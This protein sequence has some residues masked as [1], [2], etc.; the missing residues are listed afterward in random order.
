M[1]Q[2][3]LK[4]YLTYSPDTGLFH[5]ILASS[6][7]TK[8]GDLAGCMRP[9]G[10]IK[11]KIFGKSYLAHRLAWFFVH[12][13]WPDEEIDHI[14][15]IRSDNRLVNL[16]SVLK[17]QQQQNM[18]LTIKNTSGFVGVSRGRNGRWRASLVIKKKFISLGVFDTPEE[19]SSVYVAAKAKHHELFMEQQNVG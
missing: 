8:I 15:R 10:Y 19:A 5:W 17:R 18:K 11:I 6:D 4:K 3:N 2:E 13:E 1:D 12:G 9:D 14:N 16:R 7:K